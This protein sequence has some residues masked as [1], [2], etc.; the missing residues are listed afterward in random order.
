MKIYA[1]ALSDKGPFREKNEDYFCVEK[2]PALFIVADGIGGS[3]AG[4][5]ASRMAVEVV[6]DF[7]AEKEG[8]FRDLNS[9]DEHSVCATTLAEGVK[10]ANSAIF[11]ISQNNA[12]YRGMGTT[13][14]SALIFNE[15]LSVVHVGDSRAYLIRAGCIQ[16]LT[17]DHSLVAE[18]IRLGL[19]TEEDAEHSTI[20]NVITRS[21]GANPEVEADIN[22]INMADGDIV[23]LCSDGISSAL[24]NDEIAAYGK[25]AKNAEDLCRTLVN[26]AIAAGSR[27]NMTVVA[28]YIYKDAIS[29]LFN[30]IA[31]CVRRQNKDD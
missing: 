19:I 7:V 3:L 15:R 9:G 18:Q 6:R 29:H 8:D 14:T 30:S 21:I 23:I 1:S 27:D 10:L 2:A 5:V 26:S 12:S 25:N 31:S 20:K 11:D 4:E 22:E 24:T 28:V 16:Q 13:L 17:D